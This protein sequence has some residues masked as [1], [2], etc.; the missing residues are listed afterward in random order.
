MFRNTENL[1]VFAY[2]AVFFFDFSIIFEIV[3]R[4]LLKIGHIL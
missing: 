4:F 3:T 2:F 1:H